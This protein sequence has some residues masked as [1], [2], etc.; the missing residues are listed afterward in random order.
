MFNYM[1]NCSLF[2]LIVWLSYLFMCLF[3]WGLINLWR[4]NINHIVKNSSVSHLQKYN[5][6]NNF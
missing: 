1:I 4:I 2:W 6:M 5:S 3:I